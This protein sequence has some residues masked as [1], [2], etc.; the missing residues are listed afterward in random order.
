MITYEEL[1]GELKKYERRNLV[2]TPEMDK[3]LIE[4]RKMKVPFNK[5]A[6]VFSEKYNADFRTRTI[7]DRYY[8]LTR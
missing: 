4:A 7:Q 6:Q 5:I 1:M 3:A 8:E 2:W